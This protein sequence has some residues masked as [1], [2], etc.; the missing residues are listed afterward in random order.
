MT[1]S[2]WGF[3]ATPGITLRLVIN[4]NEVQTESPRSPVT[5]QKTTASLLYNLTEDEYKEQSLNLEL[6]YL[7][8]TF[9]EYLQ[10]DKV[11]IVPGLLNR[12]LSSEGG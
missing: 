1:G 12:P 9:S 3:K 11:T 4:G 5:C 7:H 10:I 2:A 6:K 8:P